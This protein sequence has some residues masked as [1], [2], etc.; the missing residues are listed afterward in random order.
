MH[1]LFI[2]TVMPGGPINVAFTNQF[3]IGNPEMNPGKLE[4]HFDDLL[5]D[6]IKR[7][8]YR[9]VQKKKKAERC[10]RAKKG[11]G[12]SKDH[13]PNEDDGQINA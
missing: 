5:V 4:I 3:Q 12:T 13:Q 7:T 2:H 8:S 9:Q 6:S 1:H 11:D 10:R